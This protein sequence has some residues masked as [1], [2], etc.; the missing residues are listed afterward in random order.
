MRSPSIATML[1]ILFPANASAAYDTGD[2]QSVALA[3]DPSANVA[4]ATG[5]S[6]YSDPIAIAMALV[7]LFAV[8]DLSIM[9]SRHLRQRRPTS[10][11]SIT[12]SERSA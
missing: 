11:S 7:A 10:D 1:A 12:L 5:Y 6:W 9:L 8:V 4:L 2:S 3:A